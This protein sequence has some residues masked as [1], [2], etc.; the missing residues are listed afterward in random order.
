MEG[1][2]GKASKELIKPSDAEEQDHGQ[3][4]SMLQDA[5]MDQLKF[6]RDISLAKKTAIKAKESDHS[7]QPIANIQGLLLLRQHKPCS[8]NQPM[9]LKAMVKGNLQ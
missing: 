9:P 8:A 2:N 7:G 3:E 5:Q 6:E 1:S 4:R